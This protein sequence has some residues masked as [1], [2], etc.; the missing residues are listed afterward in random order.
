V[1]TEAAEIG[2]SNAAIHAS[3]AG[4]FLSR[5]PVVSGFAPEMTGEFRKRELQSPMAGT[6]WRCRQAQVDLSPEQPKK[7]CR[8]GRCF[9]HLD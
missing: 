6:V 3:N 9:S 1:A 4:Q 5:T 8:H 2:A 7:R